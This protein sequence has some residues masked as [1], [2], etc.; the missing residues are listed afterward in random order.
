MTV[1]FCASD[2]FIYND[3]IIFN[4]ESTMRFPLKSSTICEAVYHPGSLILEVCFH[5]GHVYRYTG[6]PKHTVDQ[7]IDADSVG[8]F[9]NR[10]IKGKFPSMR[11]F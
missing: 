6:V 3:H 11:W 1:L 10:W 7:F 5:S 4:M 2:Y 8:R 9:Y